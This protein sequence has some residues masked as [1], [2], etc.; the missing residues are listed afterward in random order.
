MQYTKTINGRPVFSTCRTIQMPDGRWI[1]NPTTEQIAQ[2]GWRK[3]D[4]PTHVRTLEDAKTEK[5]ASL[6]AHDQSGEVLSFLFDGRPMWLNPTE[7]VN[8]LMTVNAA[9]D[10]GM[11]TVPFHGS[12]IPIAQARHILN[13]VALYAMQ[14]MAATDA[15]RASIDAMQTIADVDAYDVTRGYPTKLSFTSNV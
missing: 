9:A 7:R 4:P 1:G 5:I 11:S 6:E 2:A 15:H 3:S 8:Y 13:A 12:A 10:A 14:A